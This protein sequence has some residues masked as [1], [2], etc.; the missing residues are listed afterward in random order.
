MVLKVHRHWA[1]L[2]RWLAFPV[3]LAVLVAAADLA[4][5]SLLPADLRLLVLLATLAGLGLW[6]IAAWLRWASVS[7]TLTDQRVILEAGVLGRSSKVIAL[8][9][10]QDVSTRQSLWGRLVG[11]GTIEIDSSGPGGA[12]VFSHLPDP[13]RVRDR[14]FAQAGL[15]RQAL[16][17]RTWP[18]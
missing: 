9:R 15:R 18:G 1:L 8:D 11:Y 16:G 10:I 14:V 13:E 2:V 4:A 3:V 12:Q 7:L 5:A 17:E 6:A